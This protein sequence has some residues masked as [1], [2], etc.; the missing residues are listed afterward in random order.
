MRALSDDAFRAA[1]L[2]PPQAA[3]TTYSMQPRMQLLAQG[4][5]V[6]TLPASLL[7]HNARRWGLVT[8]PLDLGKKLPV[9]AAAFRY[10]TIGPA[11]RLFLEELRVVTKE[12]LPKAANT[13]R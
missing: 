10:R 12:Q 3:V 6:S 11:I 4:N 1:G 9:A 5:Y 7:R 8:I 2:V 13:L